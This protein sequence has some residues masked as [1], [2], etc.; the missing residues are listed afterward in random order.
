MSIPPMPPPGI[1]IA[2]FSGSSA[3]IASVMRVFLPI[4]AASRSFVHSE[5]R[6]S[7]LDKAFAIVE[8]AGVKPFTV[9]SCGE[10]TAG[11]P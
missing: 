1:A 7:H 10:A 5:L 8:I 9:V 11:N 2:S 6:R 3:T 4:E